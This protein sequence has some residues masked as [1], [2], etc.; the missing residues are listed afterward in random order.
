VLKPL[1]SLRFFAALLVFACHVPVT[2]KAAGYFLTGQAGVEFFFLLSGF[3]LIFA[4]RE[5]F[6]GRVTFAQ[7]KGFWIARFARIYPVQVL[8]LWLGVYMVARAGGFSWFFGDVEVH[9]VALLTQLTLTQSWVQIDSPFNFNT[10]AWSLSDE[11]FFYAIFPALALALFALVRRTRLWSLGILALG[12]WGI[13]VYL[14]TA[15]HDSWFF[16]TFP[17]IRLIDFAIG[18]CCGIAFLSLGDGARLRLGVATALE[19]TA[20]AGIVL[21]IAVTPSVPAL[22]GYA[23]WLAPFCAFAIYVF[24]QERGIVSKVLSSAV[25]V[26]LGEISYSFYML[27]MLIL[28]AIFVHGWKFPIVA[29]VLSLVLCVAVSA[30]VYERFEKPLRKRIRGFF[31]E[32]AP[33]PAV[34]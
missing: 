19:V 32:P 28:T 2:F 33:V 30:I 11:A 10:V 24:A 15:I 25:F 3:I 23:F 29:S 6:S 22:L 14:A 21:A 16:Y 31:T 5:L 8:S 17:P 4:H 13:G 7:V 20:V 18:A 26:Y 34:A 12:L 1:T 9:S 27:H